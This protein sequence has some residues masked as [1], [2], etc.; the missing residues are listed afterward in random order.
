M[1]LTIEDIKDIEERISHIKIINGKIWRAKH[2][3]WANTINYELL[4][5]EEKL[6]KCQITSVE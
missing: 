1:K 6:K 3:K 5:I 4:Y 2:Y